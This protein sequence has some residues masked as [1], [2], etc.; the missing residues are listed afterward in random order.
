MYRIC[1]DLRRTLWLGRYSS[2]YPLSLHR[3]VLLSHRPPC[4]TFLLGR[5]PADKL[6]Q[7]AFESG[8]KEFPW[9]EAYKDRSVTELEMRMVLE[10]KH[11]GPAKKSWFYLRDPYYVEQVH[12]PSNFPPKTI[13]FCLSRAFL[14][15]GL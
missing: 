5:S 4:L 14:T 3:G 15:C 6:L 10:G 9:I 12:C 1:W 2:R 11:N 7:K 13:R 8:G